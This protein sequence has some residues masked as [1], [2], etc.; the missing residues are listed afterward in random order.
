MRKYI[1]EFILKTFISDM[2][3]NLKYS[4]EL[5]ALTSIFIASKIIEIKK[6]D[7]KD[8]VSFGN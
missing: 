1:D 4:F 6:I 3:N 8:I 2:D 5:V 7:A